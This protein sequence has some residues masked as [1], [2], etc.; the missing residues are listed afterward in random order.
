MGITLRERAHVGGEIGAQVSELAPEIVLKVP[1]RLFVVGGDERVE[2][3][4]GERVD[5]IRPAEFGI[6]P[7]AH[8]ALESLAPVARRIHAHALRRD[9][10][11][12]RRKRGK[13]RARVLGGQT[14][15]V[16]AREQD[17]GVLVER[18]DFG[19]FPVLDGELH[20]G[21]DA[22]IQARRAAA[23]KQQDGDEDGDGHK[24]QRQNAGGC[25]P[26][27]VRPHRHGDLARVPLE[28]LRG[29][30]PVIHVGRVPLRF[31]TK[32]PFQLRAFHDTSSRSGFA[33]LLFERAAHLLLRARIMPAHRRQRH[34]EQF[35]DLPPL[36]PLRRSQHE[37]GKLFL[38]Q[39]APRKVDEQPVVIHAARP[40]GARIFPLVHRKLARA[41]AQDVDRLVAGD[42]RDPRPRIRPRAVA[43]GARKDFQIGGLHDVLGEHPLAHI[44]E[45]DIIDRPARVAVYII[46]GGAFSRRKSR[47]GIVEHIFLP[48]ASFFLLYRRLRPLSRGRRV[49]AKFRRHRRNCRPRRG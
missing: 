27:P 40:E 48:G 34:G 2:I 7:F 35:G 43:G 49:P 15:I 6:Q 12:L 31:E 41:A 28:G 13:A 45:R 46:E 39:D 5:G 9:E 47:H 17:G 44:G 38:F 20:G 24:Q 18:R 32:L 33:P 21:I 3:G 26:C 10:M 1:H 16:L 37:H 23:R 11:F 4:L 8:A 36:V 42:P 29:H 30:H 25:R 22:D 14:D 19:H